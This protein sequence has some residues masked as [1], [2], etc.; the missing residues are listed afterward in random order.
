MERS[1]VVWALAMLRTKPVHGLATLWRVLFFLVLGAIVGTAL[2]ALHVWSGAS[3]YSDVPLMP[4]LNVAWYVPPEFAIAGVTVGLLR[5]ELDEELNRPR[6]DLPAWQVAGGM[7]LLAVVWAASGLLGKW[8][9]SNVQITA[10]LLPAGAAGWFV[11]DR[12]RQGVIAALLTAAIGVLVESA[13]TWTGT[14]AYTRPDFL[15]VPMWL[16]T[17]YITACGAVG[18]FGRFLKYSWDLPEAPAEQPAET[19]AKVA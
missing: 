14:Y 13:L 1:P 8:G 19:R 17:L 6:S 16:P 5:P 11:F 12:T 7:A 3:R 10:L 2:D 18:N 4:V 15:G 9:L